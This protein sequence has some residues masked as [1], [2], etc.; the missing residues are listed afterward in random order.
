MRIVR[1][2][3][4]SNRPGV[5]CYQIRNALKARKASG[6]FNPVSLT[7]FEEAYKILSE[8]LR[9]QVYTLGFLR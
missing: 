2:T 9:P 1:D 3:I 4:K 5:G 8:K 6:D 7:E